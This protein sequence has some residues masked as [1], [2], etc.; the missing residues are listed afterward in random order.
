MTFILIENIWFN[1]NNLNLYSIEFIKLS[2]KDIEFL[3][4][5]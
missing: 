1:I 2:M 4:I 3:D 5:F